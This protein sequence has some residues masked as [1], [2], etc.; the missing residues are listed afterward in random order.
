MADPIKVKA[1]YGA[2]RVVK[3]LTKDTFKCRCNKCRAPDELSSEI[4]NDDPVC[5]SC[6]Y[7]GVDIVSDK[8]PD[9]LRD[10]L[11]K[12]KTTMSEGGDLEVDPDMLESIFGTD[13]SKIMSLISSAEEKDRGFSMFQVRMLITLIDMVPILELRVRNTEGS[14]SAVYSLN[15]MINSI[16]EL[17]NDMQANQE[18]SNLAANI[19]EKVMYPIFIGFAHMYVSQANMLKT[20]L[21]PHIKDKRWAKVEDAVLQC[22]R[23]MGKRTEEMYGK[24]NVDL[25]SFLE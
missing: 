3:T 4:L 8:N 20:A 24:I 22:F 5:D 23:D 17:I 11:V 9:E 7:T 15:A 2:F 12:M 6:G 1:T 14:Q 13:S 10:Y 19:S 18:Q 21:A 25:K 16:R